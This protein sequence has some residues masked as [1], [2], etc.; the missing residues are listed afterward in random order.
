MY[1][2]QEKKDEMFMIVFDNLW[3]T[4]QEKGIS[5]YKLFKEYNFSHGQLS[6][7]KHNDN[8]NSHTINMLCEILD[9]RVEDIME[10]KKDKKQKTE[11]D[12][13]DNPSKL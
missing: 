7:L 2:I 9:C 8:I 12:N 3:K 11:L 5:Q 6:R 4:M 10:Y 1:I 13:P